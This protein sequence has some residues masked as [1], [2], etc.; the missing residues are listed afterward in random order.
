MKQQTPRTPK[1]CVHLLI[2]CSFSPPLLG[3]VPQGTTPGPLTL[4]AESNKMCFF[5]FNPDGIQ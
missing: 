5:L 4:S 1:V 2:V 3:G